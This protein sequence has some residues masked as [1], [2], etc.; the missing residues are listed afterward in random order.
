MQPVGQLGD[1]LDALRSNDP[2]AVVVSSIP[3]PQD[4]RRSLERHRW[5]HQQ[6]EIVALKPHVADAQTTGVE[7]CLR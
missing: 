4:K 3:P 2:G 1:R 7:Q 6:K 5:P